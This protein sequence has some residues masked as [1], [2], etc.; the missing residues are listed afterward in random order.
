MK[1]NNMKKK[2]DACHKGR[3][4]NKKYTM[5][6]RKFTIH[7]KINNWIKILKITHFKKHMNRKTDLPWIC[8]IKALNRNI[9]K[10]LL[11][12]INQ[13]I[14]LVRYA[15]WW[16]R[17]HQFKALEIMLEIQCI[18]AAVAESY[19]KIENQLPTTILIII[20]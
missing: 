2:I 11:L 8:W 12:K 1:L 5:K 13:Q 4:L 9:S 10:Y 16:V 7:S 20:K 6:K 15:G 14:G 18:L 3:Y 17:G 19:I